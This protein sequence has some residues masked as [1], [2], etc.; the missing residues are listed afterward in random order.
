MSSKSRTPAPPLPEAG[1]LRLSR[2][3]VS[4][5]CAALELPRPHNCAIAFLSVLLG[6][7]L[8]AHAISPPLLLAALSAALIMGAGNSHNDLCD[9]GADRINRPDRPLPSGRLPAR[10]AR[11]EAA[12]L[13][14]GG[15]GLALILPP[16]IPAL[17]LSAGIGLGLYNTWLKRVPLIGN[18]LVGLLCALAF[19]YGGAAVH[20]PLPAVVPATFVLLFHLGR[21]ILKDVEDSAGDRLLPGTT[22]PLRWG[23]RKA[24]ALVTAIFLL[25]VLSTPVPVLTGHYGLRYLALVLPLNALLIYTV[26]ALWRSRPPA[27]LRRLNR[28]LKI[29]MLIGLCAIFIDS[30]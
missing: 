15:I 29:G 23:R 27:N 11:L 30:L 6:G 28:L 8:G 21:E 17:A 1:P 5:L 25:L 7:W 14:A 2:R 18:L 22:L 4:T 26:L 9:I 13:A 3:A 10:V 24:Y 16:P 20:A 19:F 12:G